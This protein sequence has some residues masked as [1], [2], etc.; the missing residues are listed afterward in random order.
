MS[1]TPYDPARAMADAKHEFGEHGGVNMSIEAST[2]FT[3]MAADTMPDIFA[4]EKG[5][6]QGGCFLYGR[7]FNPTVFALGRQI[8]AMENTEM[9][10]GTASGLAAVAAAVTQLCN[11]GDHCVVSDTVYGGTYALF[12][13]YFPLKNNITAT[14]VDANDLDAVRAAVTPKTRVVYAETMANPTLK[15]PDLAGIADIAH[16]AGASLVVDNTFCPMMVTPAHHGADVVVHSLTKFANG[17]SDII[18]GAVCGSEEFIGSLMDL[19]T[20][21]LML[22]GPTMDPNAA[23][24]IA[25][26]LPHLGIRMQEHS[27]RAQLFAERLEG[28][29]V[30]VCYPGL[31]AHPDH[32]RLAAMLNPG[33]GFGGL[34][35]ID[36]GTEARAMEFM[37]RLQNKHRFGFMAVS[38]GYFDTLM[39]CSGS[40]TSSEMT[41][42]DK[43]AAG[44]KPGLVRMS[45]GYTG[46]VEDRWGELVETLETLNMVTAGSSGR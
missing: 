15:I 5:P 16:T 30:P 14:F 20:G 9:A 42:E 35:A 43:I 12:K 41:E 38:L 46:N 25:L 21:S 44:I 36:L 22:L 37:D 28:L 17:A 6:T 31:A 32:D 1:T 45:L 4:G 34:L 27:R 33:Y 24:H 23:F 3:V 39:S 8:A 19:H 26:R 40:S 18:A 10:Y 11:A 7:H 2:T 29:G 13:E